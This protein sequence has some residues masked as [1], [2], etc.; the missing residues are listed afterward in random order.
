MR[1]L[2][3]CVCGLLALAPGAW[4]A[5]ATAWEMNSY[6]DF[7]NKTGSALGFQSMMRMS[8]SNRT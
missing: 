5:G 1:I 8:A 4:A 6:Q 2:Q 7:I 3:A